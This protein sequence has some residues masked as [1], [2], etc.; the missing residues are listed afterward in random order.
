M[1]ALVQAVQGRGAGVPMAGVVSVEAMEGAGVETRVAPVL[2]VE[3]LVLWWPR[4][5]RHTPRIQAS[6]SLFVASCSML[7]ASG[8]GNYLVEILGR[9]LVGGTSSEPMGKGLVSV[10]LLLSSSS[11]HL[12]RLFLVEVLSRNE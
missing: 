9:R 8:T 10:H 2:G 11:D 1:P 7:G 3:Q 4:R 6:G 5:R 12:F